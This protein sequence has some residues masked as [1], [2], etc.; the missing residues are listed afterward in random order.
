MASGRIK[1]ITIEIGGDTTNLQKSLSGVDKSLRQTQNNLKDVNKLL[2]LDPGNTELLTQKQKNLKDA[3]GQTKDR[4]KQLKDAQSGVKEGTAEWDALQREIIDTEQQLDKLKSQYRD[5][6][7]VAKQ[8]LQAVGDKLKEVGGKVTDFGEKLAP[9]S[10]AAAAL[11]GAMLKLGYDSI[12]SADELKTLSQQTGISTDSL[13]KM[14]YA[15]ELVDVSVEDITGALKK[16]KPKM[17]DNNKTFEKLGVSVKDANG[18]LRSAEDVFYDSIEALG[19]I[20]NETERDQVAMELF[21]KSADSLAGIIDDGGAAMKAFGQE[22]EDMG[23]I[24]DEETIGSLADTD[25][26]IQKLKAQLGGTMAQIGAD[27]ASVLGPALEKAAELIGKITERLRALTPEQTETILKIVGIVAAI[28][29]VI[30]LVGKIISGIGALTSAIGFLMSPMGLIVVAIAA[31]IAIGVALYKNWDT[32]CA[33][34]NKVKEQVVK[35]WNDLKTNVSHAVNTLKTA[36]TNAWNAIKTVVT[37]TANNIKTGVTNAWNGIKTAVGNVTDNMKSMLQG[38]LD[39]IKKAYEEHGGG[40][41]GLAS[42]AVTAIKEYWTTGFDTINTLLGGKLDGIKEKFTS[43]F[44]TVKSTVENALNKI[45]GMFNF[46]WSLP[47]IKLP[48]FKISGSFSLSPPSVPSVSI[49]W[50]RKAYENPY[51]F[52]TPTIVSGKGFGDGGGSGEIV[53][54]RDQLLSDIAIASGRDQLAKDIYTAMSAALDH[55]DTTIV[56][57]GRE[58]GRILREQGAIA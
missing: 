13:Q 30:I 49:D 40:I 17:T 31:V 45:K 54:G 36:I 47:S 6:G 3:I 57:S 16:M 53:Y 51:L 46:S 18:Q 41:K 19:K 15:S 34:A 55:M 4:L 20:Q 43:A 44:D 35:A 1:G 22:A 21:G 52:T 58:F 42:A 12:T 38:K 50:Y 25:D 37:N 48:H 10:G 27:V 23:L 14:Q 5:F 11:G 32:I 9:V 24:L 2:K 7:S 29:P 26:T 56:I 28:A 33:W 39:N 8:Q